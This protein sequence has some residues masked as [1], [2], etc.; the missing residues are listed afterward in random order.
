MSDTLTWELQGLT[1][2][3]LRG[4]EIVLVQDHIPDGKPFASEEDAS[5]WAMLYVAI[6]NAV[7][8]TPVEINEMGVVN[9]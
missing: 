8:N 2:H 1:V 6:M 9:L 4:D 3:I 5:R 7:N